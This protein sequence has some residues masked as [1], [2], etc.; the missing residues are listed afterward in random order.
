[1][2]LA[3]TL[4]PDLRGAAVGLHAQSFLILSNQKKRVEGENREVQ[5]QSASPNTLAL[6]L[7]VRRK[8]KYLGGNVCAKCG[9]EKPLECRKPE[10]PTKEEKF[11]KR[12]IK[13]MK[14]QN[15]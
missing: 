6:C 1:M 2:K 4:C 12:M 13:I 14:E 7:G 8:H 5:G 10:R 11:Y 15:A 3:V 9:R